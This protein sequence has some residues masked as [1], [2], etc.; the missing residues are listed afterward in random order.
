MR[1]F[2]GDHEEREKG[3]GVED[4]DGGVV[5]HTRD[6]T[7]VRGVRVVIVVRLKGNFMNGP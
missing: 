5:A 3:D 4:L 6:V 7:G 2:V 1:L